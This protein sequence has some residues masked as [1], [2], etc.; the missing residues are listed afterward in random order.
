MGNQSI[1]IYLKNKRKAI[2][3]T[4]NGEQENGNY[5]STCHAKTS[6]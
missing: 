5:F 6:I 2:H 4:P 1:F 3:L